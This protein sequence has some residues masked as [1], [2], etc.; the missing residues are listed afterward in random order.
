MEKARIYSCYSRARRIE[1]FKI[2]IFKTW[3]WGSPIMKVQVR[4][5]LG[6]YT[7]EDQNSGFGVRLTAQGAL[8][9]F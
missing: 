2:Y 7:S 1:D 8:G 4:D 3:H 9:K 6:L 5:T